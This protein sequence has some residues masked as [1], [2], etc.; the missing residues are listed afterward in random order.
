MRAA[1]LD[2]DGTL[3]GP[4]GALLRAQDGAWSVDGVRALER[5]HRAGVE[6][7]LVSGRARGALAGDARLLG[8]G[9]Y[10]CELG[11]CVVVDGREHWSTG[12]LVPSAASGTVFEQVAASGAP[13]LLLE[14]FGGRL[15]EHEPWH[16]GRE[17][18]HLLRG[19][20]DVAVAQELLD[21]HGLGHLRLLDNGVVERRSLALQAL[22]EV[23]AYHLLPRDASKVAGV[24]LHQ[25]LRG[26]NPA[27]CLAVGD[28]REDLALAA[29]VG[30]CVLVANAAARDPEIG[31][32]AAALPGVW[33]AR[34]S[35]GAGVLEAVERWLA[36]GQWPQD[37]AWG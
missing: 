27:A 33:M 21:S 31:V 15:E 37:P 17:V 3:L 30:T 10:V 4:D 12:G 14:H 22:P 8:V 5:C 35:H 18:T 25:E 19:L 24:V 7:V 29:R 13:A 20:V 16:R 26:L 6:V 11:A 23:H 1:Y 32:M 28:S 2:L 36:D 34:G 9:S